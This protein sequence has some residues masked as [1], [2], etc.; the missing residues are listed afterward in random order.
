VVAFVNRIL[1]SLHLIASPRSW[2]D[3][4]PETVILG[5]VYGYIPYM[6]LPL[7]GTLDTI[8]RSLLEEARDLGA[9]PFE[10]F[11]R[12]TWPLSRQTV[13][14]GTLIVGLPITGDYY[15]N[16]LLSGSP[17]TT[18][19]AN[20]IDFL[21]HTRNSGPTIGAA[22]V[23]LLTLALVIPMIYYLRVVGEADFER[24]ETTA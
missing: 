15:T 12:V 9:R 1:L 17:R 5:L 21:L 8:D 2:L 3:G 20:Q 13:I 22:M 7:F 18:M 11:R 24:D 4:R 6:I 14:A 19:I 16:N 10:V 23:F